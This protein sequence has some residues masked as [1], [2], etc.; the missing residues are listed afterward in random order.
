MRGN[1]I[2]KNLI[3][4]K[5]DKI[6]TLHYT[7]TRSYRYIFGKLNTINI[8]KEILMI[9]I[10]SSIYTWMQFIYGTILKSTLW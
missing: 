4:K 2:Q 8:F 3:K 10:S 5:H 1:C 9:R 7:M 6:N